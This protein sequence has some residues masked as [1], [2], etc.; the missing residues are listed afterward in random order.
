M[1]LT[2]SQIYTLSGGN[3]TLVVPGGLI[4]VGLANPPSFVGPR[5]ASVRDALADGPKYFEQLMAALGTADGREVVVMLDEL[6]SEGVLGRE[7]AEGR[8]KLVD[9]KAGA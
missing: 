3:I 7:A 8:Y 4:D 1:T 6:R 2:T 9:K 5:F